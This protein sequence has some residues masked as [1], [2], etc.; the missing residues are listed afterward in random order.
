[1][2]DIIDV[3]NRY[4]L[5]PLNTD[6]GEPTEA[7][8]TNDRKTISPEMEKMINDARPEVEKLYR[9]IKRIGFSGRKKG[10]DEQY[11]DAA[12]EFFRENRSDFKLVKEEYLYDGILYSFRPRPGQEK[13]CFIGKLLQKIAHEAD[14]GIDNYQE[15]YQIYKSTKR[16]Q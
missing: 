12:I 9:P 14:L 7:N 15:L 2:E 6:D 4:E 8:A 5:N 10:T 11:K 3:E 1:M 16:L 13:G